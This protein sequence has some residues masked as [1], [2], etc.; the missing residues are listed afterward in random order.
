MMQ[1][2]SFLPNRK[3]KQQMKHM[4]KTNKQANYLRKEK[5]QIIHKR[6]I[7]YVKA[8]ER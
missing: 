1:Q 6:A 2:V 7:S 5:T 4:R 3:M 8:K